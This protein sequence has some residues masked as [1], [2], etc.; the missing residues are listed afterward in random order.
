MGSQEVEIGKSNVNRKPEAE[1]LE[2]DKIQRVKAMLEQ[3]KEINMETQY[4]H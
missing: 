4:V 2:E 1:I 3:N